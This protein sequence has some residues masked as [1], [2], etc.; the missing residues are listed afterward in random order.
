M[1]IRKKAEQS[2]RTSEQAVS[3]IKEFEA[4]KAEP[5]QCPKKVWTIGYG[6]TRYP[7]GLFVFANDPPITEKQAE[8]YLLHYL[9]LTCMKL[10]NK[11]VKVNLYQNQV[12]ALA[13][14]LY[15]IK[16]PDKNWPTSTMLKL[17]NEGRSDL[18][19]AQFDRWI[20][21]PPLAGLV[22]RRAL[23]RKLFEKHL[24]E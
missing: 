24:K 14:F 1:A 16:N 9:N 20:G 17:I 5:Y 21:Q 15:N 10:L 2:F 23:E 6:T 22:R 18:A 11:T 7:N 13:S 4:F 12:D 8:Q 3:I 19:A